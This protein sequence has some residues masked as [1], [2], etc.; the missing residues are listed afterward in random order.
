MLILISPLKALANVGRSATLRSDASALI[1][2]SRAATTI[3]AR[4]SITIR[5]SGPFASS[6]PKASSQLPAGWLY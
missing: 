6:L 5:S 3:S 1:A 2:N 4:L